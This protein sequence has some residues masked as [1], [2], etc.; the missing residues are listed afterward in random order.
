M[1]KNA[2]ITF[3]LLFVSFISYSQN[4]NENVTFNSIGLTYDSVMTYITDKT[5]VLEKKYSLVRDIDEINLRDMVYNIYNTVLQQAK[6]EK[7]IEYSINLYCAIADN[8]MQTENKFEEAKIYLDSAFLLEKKTTDLSSLALMN[9]MMARYY[10]IM[11]QEDKA[12]EYLY[13]TI[14]YFEQTEGKKTTALLLLYSLADGYSQHNDI[15]GLK[16]LFDKMQP[17]ASEI[18]DSQGFMQTYNVAVAYYSKLYQKNTNNQFYLDSIISYNKKNVDIYNKSDEATQKIVEGFMVQSILNTSE[19]MMYIT[20]P[21][22]I[23]ISNNLDVV[24]KMNLAY[25]IGST[26][27]KIIY[28]RLKA[29]LS[30]H[31][32]NYIEANKEASIALD[33]M[34]NE[35][36]DKDLQ[37]YLYIYTLLVEINEQKGDYKTALNYSKLKDQIKMEINDLSKYEVIKELESKYETTKN[38]LEISKLNEEKQQTHYKTMIMVACFVTI[39]ILLILAILYGRM[40]RL[41]K[42]KEAAVMSQQIEEKEAKYQS[43]LNET[44]VK[45]MHQYL[46]GLES[47]RNRLAKELHDGVSNELVAI[48]MQIDNKNNT[49]SIISSLG[50]LHNKIRSISHDLMPPVFQYASLPEILTDYVHNLNEVSKTAFSLQIAN[51]QEIADIPH[52]SALEI[53]RIVQEASG[54]ILKYA[55]ADNAEISLSADNNNIILNINDNGEGFDTAQKRVGIGLQIIKSRAKSLNGTSDIESRIGKGSSIHVVIPHLQSVKE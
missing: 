42:E 31:N 11:K 49:D 36:P 1:K 18:N 48:K 55:D 52:E 5:V 40:K 23:T 50:E 15:A 13:K 53:Y 39:A 34:E 4:N 26:D 2:I 7:Q 33:I 46:K 6:K 3:F 21:D 9:Y 41:K 35:M 22:W 51:D 8:H 43:L 38:E 24:E 45:K 17:L 47:E 20:D 54:N 29:S 27:K 30:L 14:E 19:S 25:H 16:K 28:H 44:E 32:K 37:M 10:S 12:H